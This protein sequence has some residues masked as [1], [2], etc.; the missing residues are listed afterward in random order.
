MFQ[1]RFLDLVPI[2]RHVLLEGMLDGVIVLD[3]QDRIVDINPAAIRLIKA[4]MSPPIGEKIDTFLNDWHAIS[5]RC[6]ET[7]KYWEEIRFDGLEMRYFDLRITDL[8]DHNGRTTGKLVDFRDITTHKNTELQ[9]RDANVLLQ[10][11]LEEIKALQDELREQAIRDPLTGLYNRRYL[12]EMLNRELSKAKR[13][14]KSVSVVMIDIDTF[15][16]CNDTFGHKAGDT[17]LQAVADMFHRN[18]RVEDIVCR[19]GGDEFLIVLPDTPEQVG[20]DCAERWRELVQN[21]DI[22]YEQL[23]LKVTI[24]VGVA[25]FP[26]SGRTPDEILQTADKALYWAKGIGRNRVVSFQQMQQEQQ[27]SSR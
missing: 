23:K 14:G 27:T 9:L 8:Y 16:T 19:F 17:I 11:Q 3:V 1:F 24:S 20:A 12:N 26:N 7:G 6:Y 2:A 5:A 15:K 21:I 22:H 25:S 18:T 10:D 4:D 13:L